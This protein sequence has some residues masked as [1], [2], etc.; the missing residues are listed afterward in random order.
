[1][2]LLLD[3]LETGNLANIPCVERAYAVFVELERKGVHKLAGLAVGYVSRALALLRRREKEAAEG[4][5]SMAGMGVGGATGIERPMDTVMGNTGMLL[6]EDPGLQSFKPEPFA[7]PSWDM[8]GRDLHPHSHSHPRPQSHRPIQQQ[9]QQQQ[10]QL[11]QDQYQQQQQNHPQH[12]HHQQ[13]FS[14][15]FPQP[16]QHIP[17]HPPQQLPRQHQHQHQHQHY[18]F[19]L[20]HHSTPSSPFQSHPSQPNPFNPS[21]HLDLRNAAAMDLGGNPGW[22]AR[23]TTAVGAEAGAGAGVADEAQEWG[24][25]G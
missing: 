12:H 16:H 8:A 18:P 9:Q 3:A 24:M 5:A 20:Q 22:A 2:I 13:P 25:D 23:G 4:E 10:P 11:Q 14:P 15:F 17:P 19:P 21:A 1:M 7:P 6:L